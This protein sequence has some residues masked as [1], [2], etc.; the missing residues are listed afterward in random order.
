MKSVNIS[1]MNYCD[2]KHKQQKSFKNKY[3]I[4]INK[5]LNFNF[6]HKNSLSISY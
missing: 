1:D 2:M 6:S 5:Y 3:L 4:L